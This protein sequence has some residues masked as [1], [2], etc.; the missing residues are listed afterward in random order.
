MPENEKN[1]MTV[2]ENLIS[3][4]KKE[5]NTTFSELVFDTAGF[6]FM[7]L[8]VFFLILTFFVRQVNVDGPSMNDTLQDKD[9]LAVWTFMYEPQPKDIVII[10]HGA[11]LDKMIIKRVIA[12]GGQK[13]DINY[14]KNEVSVDGVL[15]RE[16][17]IKG[18]TV[19]PSMSVKKTNL[20]IPDGYVFVM[21]DNRENSTD[22]RSV[23]VDLVPVQNIIGKA[24]F[25]F[26]PFDKF[27]TL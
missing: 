10:T 21:G 6:I 13:L 9:R 17:Y 8:A 25:R 23:L 11:N 12:V 16:D 22:S 18:R 27:G 3:S 4:E 20:V 15:L 26:T 2:H 24:F 7:F 14:D 19:R 5:E 1:Q